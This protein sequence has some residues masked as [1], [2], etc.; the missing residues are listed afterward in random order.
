MN[1]VY[2]LNSVLAL[3]IFMNPEKLRAL[4]DANTEPRQWW[5]LG[6]PRVNV[7][8]LNLALDQLAP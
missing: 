2:L 7:L 1:W 5:L 4:I 8:G 3:S 6:E